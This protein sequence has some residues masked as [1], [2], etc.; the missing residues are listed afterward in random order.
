MHSHCL[1][2][3]GCIRFAQLQR[4]LNILRI[5]NSLQSQAHHH[6][7]PDRSKILLVQRTHLLLPA[8]ILVSHTPIAGCCHWLVF[9]RE[10]VGKGSEGRARGV[11]FGRN[12]GK[13][14]TSLIGRLGL[15][16]TCIDGWL[17]R[18]QTRN[19]IWQARY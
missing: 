9:G 7:Y 4:R 19:P 16:V 3:M 11:K 18:S 8:N 12:L 5:L 17:V 2:Y 13:R 15:C 1:L 10:T 14:A 6:Y